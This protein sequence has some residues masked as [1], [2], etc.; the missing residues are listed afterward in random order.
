MN[1][2][3]VESKISIWNLGNTEI[4]DAETIMFVLPSQQ[5]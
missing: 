2:Q 3:I 5:W 4:N 1:L